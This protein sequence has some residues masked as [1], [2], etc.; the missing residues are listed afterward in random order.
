MLIVRAQK[1]C[2]IVAGR[3]RFYDVPEI[4]LW[5]FG[6]KEKMVRGPET[7]GRF[8]PLLQVGTF[9]N[10]IEPGGIHLRIGGHKYLPVDQP[11]IE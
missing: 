8:N 1:R 7:A 4:G 6:G 11:E 5:Q 2:P 3:S 10:E 9:V